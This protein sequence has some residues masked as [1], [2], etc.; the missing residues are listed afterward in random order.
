MPKL[1]HRKCVS[2]EEFYHRDE[3]YM[4]AGASSFDEWVCETCYYEDQPCCSY[5]TPTC[6]YNGNIG[7]YN[8]NLDDPLWGDPCYDAIEEHA[9]SIEWKSTDAWR[10]Y[11]DG[12]VPDG[13][14]S[15]IEGWTSGGWG[16]GTDEVND[17]SDVWENNKQC[18]EGLRM[19]VA[20]YRTSNVFSTSV[21]VYVHNQDVDE[22][23]RILVRDAI[24]EVLND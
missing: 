15:M 9:D 17:F 18:F 5:V 7:S 3:M 11:F 22:F 2:C 1:D 6:E 19:F 24:D 4:S 20:L 14:V 21:D 16:G 13:Y 12:K 10:G 8:R 23:K